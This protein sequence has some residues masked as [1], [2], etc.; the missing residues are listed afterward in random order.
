MNNMKSGSSSCKNSW[1]N[2]GVD[3][4]VMFDMG[5][6]G[7]CH[8]SQACTNEELMHTLVS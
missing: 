3:G 6:R 1:K 7:F 8:G 4:H 5:Y 2:Y